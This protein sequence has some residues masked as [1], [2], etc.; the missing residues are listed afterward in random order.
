MFEVN[1]IECPASQCPSCG[2][3]VDKVIQFIWN[4]EEFDTACGDCMSDVVG[5]LSDAAEK[6]EFA[7]YEMG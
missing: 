5:M 6:L 3:P 4:G 7:I 1:V 2:K